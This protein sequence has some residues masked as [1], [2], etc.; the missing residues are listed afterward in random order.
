MKI[1][2]NNKFKFIYILTFI[3]MIAVTCRKDDDDR[4]NSLT[5][6]ETEFL[7][8][9]GYLEIFSPEQDGGD[10]DIILTDGEYI[11]DSAYYYNWNTFVCFDLKSVSTTEL[12]SGEYVYNSGWLPGS[13]YYSFIS[14][15]STAGVSFDI[16]DGTVSV[17]KTGDDY[18]ISYDVT[19]GSSTRV[20]GFFKGPLTEIDNTQ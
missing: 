2:L 20:T 17:E 10:F 4:K 9:N 14:M 5:V 19:I 16:T 12:T 7:T 11:A 1:M 13:F 6:Y 3:L 18:E 15:Y 8:P